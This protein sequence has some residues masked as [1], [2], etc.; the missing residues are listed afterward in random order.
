MSEQAPVCPDCGHPISEEIKKQAAGRKGWRNAIIVVAVLVGIVW[1]LSSIS[2]NNSPTPDSRPAPFVRHGS[3]RASEVTGVI[4]TIDRDFAGNIVL[5]LDEGNGSSTAGLTLDDNRDYAETLSKGETVTASCKDMERVLNKAEGNHC[6]IDVVGLGEE[7][8]AS[9]RGFHKVAHSYIACPDKS[10]MSTLENPTKTDPRG[11]WKRL[12]A[13][14]V[15]LDRGENVDVISYDDVRTSGVVIT[16]VRVP[17]R[18][19]TFWTIGDT[20]VGDVCVRNGVGKAPPCHQY[21][22]PY[23]TMASALFAAYRNYDVPWQLTNGERPVEITGMVRIIDRDF[24]NGDA[25]LTLYTGSRSWGDML[26]VPDKVKAAKLSRGETVTVL[27]KGVK[28]VGD[29]LPLGSQCG[30]LNIEPEDVTVN[31]RGLHKIARAGLAC[32]SEVGMLYYIRGSNEIEVQP[33]SPDSDDPMGLA[34]FGNCGEYTKRGEVV[35][36]VSY[37][38]AGGSVIMEVR[39]PDQPGTF[40]I[41]GD[42]L[43]GEVAPANDD[44]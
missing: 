41:P 13:D 38:K 29:Y 44:Q 6:S 15:G 3:K 19:G 28:P 39:L 35:D 32:P 42:A 11:F 27:C 5:H 16:E 12:N 43:L 1:F 23:R 4:R 24:G 9:W 37:D 21:T 34:A 33:G 14:C 22:V 17:G 25:A 31:W 8:T 7:V 30:I 20:L 10:E 26:D 40:W 18:P 36:V 2:E